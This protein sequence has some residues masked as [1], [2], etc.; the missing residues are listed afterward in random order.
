VLPIIPEKQTRD[1]Q[2]E[3][4]CDA[5]RSRPVDGSSEVG[6]QHALVAVAVPPVPASCPWEQ[7]G[8]GQVGRIRRYRLPE[9]VLIKS[10]G[11]EPGEYFSRPKGVQA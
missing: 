2:R 5:G 9:A 10:G 3:G 8:K 7:A 6:L 4:A 1:K 11:A